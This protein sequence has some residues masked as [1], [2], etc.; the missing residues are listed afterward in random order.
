L[1]NNKELSFLL[2]LLLKKNYKERPDIEEVYKLAIQIVNNNKKNEIKLIIE[3][4]KYD[5]N[6][7]IPILGDLKPENGIVTYL[8]YNCRDFGSDR[9]ILKEL[10]ELNTELYINDKK[11]KFSKFCKFSK[12]G[13]YHIKLK[14]Q[15][16][17]KD[18]SYMFF[19]CYNLTSIDLSSFITNNVTNM[20]AMFGWCVNLKNINFSSFNTQNVTDMN[21]MF[22]GCHHLT[23]LDLSSFNTQ[24]VINM[25]HMFEA[26]HSLTNLDLSSFN[27]KNVSKMAKMFDSCRE[28]KSINLNSF[29]TGNLINMDFMFQGCINLKN[30]DLSSFDKIFGIM[31][32]T[33]VNANI[34]INKNSYIDK[35]CFENSEIN[36]TYI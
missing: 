29:K 35:N 11:T 30:I 6:K 26:C 31:V 3:I 5:I 28:L 36:I 9:Q 25:S 10:N 24:N 16:E 23:N 13:I 22:C 27:T 12:E 14:F 32:F 19:K 17:I 20:E 4:G 1:N 34:I 33:G 18:C 7:N 8:H 21:S 2:D 15:I